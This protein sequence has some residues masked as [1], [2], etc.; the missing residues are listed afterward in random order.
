MG[1]IHI[2]TP[3]YPPKTGGVADY[4]RLVARGL[5]EAGETV[6]VWCPAEAAVDTDSAFEVHPECGRFH[7]SD[8]A[9]LGRL[10]DRF[11]RPRRLL[12]QW[13]P[14]GYGR[15]AM[16][17]GF[18]LWVWRR[19]RRGDQI[20]VMVHEPYLAFWEGGWRQA[21]AALVHRFM[22]IVLLR[23]ASRVWVAI[24]AWEDRWRPYT[25]GR[26]VPFAWLPVPSVLMVPDSAAVRA[27]RDQ[28]S[29][30]PLIGHLGTYGPLVASLLDD[31]LKELLCRLDEGR[32]VLMG[33]G[34]DAFRQRFSARYPG[35]APRIVA[36]GRLAD[37]AL[38]AHV[39]ACDVL[40]QPYPDGVSSRRTTAMAGLRLGVPLVTTSGA[41]TESFWEPSRAVRLSPAG[42]WARMV[43][44]VL[45]LLSH[46]D[47]RRTL[48]DSGRTFYERT[49]DVRRTVAAL[50]SAT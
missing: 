7:A 43:E 28:F 39:A 45:D 27:V 24:P 4:T 36:T 1:T 11:D 32:I 40:V 18:C 30:G 9:R 5:Y 20:E 26:A 35:L 41:L 49:F 38:A 13:V 3:E 31:V 21:A 46:P 10:L 25:L 2:L 16:N 22:T 44:H 17:V 29:D 12:L 6:H 34:G 42:D 47:A 19:A 14:H 33:A 8:L 15:R 23:A 37:H 50:M 48:A